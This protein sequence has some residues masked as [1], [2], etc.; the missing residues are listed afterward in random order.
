MQ[1]PSSTRTLAL[2]P[3]F[4]VDVDVGKPKVQAN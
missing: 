4:G 1:L 3:R 2:Q